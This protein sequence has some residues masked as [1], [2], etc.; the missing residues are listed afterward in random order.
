MKMF[1]I[2]PQGKQYEVLALPANG[3]IVVLGTAGSGKTTI[4]LLRA[5]HL[6]NILNGGRVLL[7]TF[8]RALAE[9]IRGMS[10]LGLTNLV[11]EN[12][13]KFARGYLYSRGK[14]S[15]LN[16]ILDP[17]GKMNL[18]EVAVKSMKKKFPRES[19]FH[20]PKEFF[21]DEISFIQ[22]FGF[23]DFVAYNEAERIGRAAANIKREK[24]KWVFAVYEKYIRLREESGYQYDWDD[25]AFYAYKEMQDDDGE[26]R[27]THIIVDEG[28]DFSPMMLKSLVEAVSKDG[29]FTFFGDVAQQIYGNRLSWRDSGINVEKIWRFDV[30]Y[31]NPV[32]ITAF[33]KDL[34]ESKYWQENGDIIEATNRIA[35]GPK[36]VLVHFSNKER[37]ISWVVAQAISKRNVSSTAIICRSRADIVIFMRM[38]MNKGCRPTEIDKNTPGYAYNKTVYLTTFHSAKGLEFDN[39]YVP[40]IS[41]EKLPDP[42]VVDRAVSVE[43][44]YANE[45]KLLY[46]AATRTKYGLYMSYSGT[47]TPLFPEGAD[48]YNFYEGDAFL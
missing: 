12:Y 14:M 45:L 13:H 40:F 30:N 7:V 46:V 8:N 36:P 24:R 48:S 47:L 43:D 15:N 20:R 22:K 33:T 37:E 9:Y 38:L 25:L 21:V 41:A 28:Q 32:A 2:K 11:V 4:A 3:H 16:G 19:T 34:T 1:K 26:R 5:C 29:S 23:S 18:I 44:A 42:D 10:N 39:V 27:Y 31:R 6:A 17:V 35:E